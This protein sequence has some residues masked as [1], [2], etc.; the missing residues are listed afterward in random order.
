LTAFITFDKV[1]K[2]SRLF[3]RMIKKI[4]FSAVLLTA[5]THISI[6]QTKLKTG[7]W[8]GALKTAS[9]NEIPFNFEVTNT[10]GKQEL[11]IINSTEHFKVTDVT[12]KGDSVFIKMPLFDSE[13]RLK[14]T[15]Q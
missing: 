9:G 10:G 5:L 1:Y 11:A 12:G 7:I 2:I 3:L 4:L 14:Q 13:F 8:R 15:W 6:A